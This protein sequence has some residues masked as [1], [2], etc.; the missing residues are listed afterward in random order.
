MDPSPP[1]GPYAIQVWGLTKTF[2]HH[3]VL[4]GVDLQ[5]RKG[6]LLA[7]FGPNGAGKTTLLKV[8][9]TLL[10]PSSGRAILDGLE[11]R[12]E[13][14]VLRR[15]LGVLTHQT[16]LYD[17]LTPYENLQFYGRM[18][19]VPRLPQ[20]IQELLER[21]GLWSRRHDPVRTLS[22]GMQKRVSLARALLHDPPILLL[23]EPEAGL[24]QQASLLLREILA[25]FTRHGR[26]AIM[27][28]HSL[29][30]GLEVADQ[31]AI[32]VGGRLV[33]EEAKSSLDVA[34]FQDIY[35]RHVGGGG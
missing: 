20:R 27:T 24:D 17:D 1:E 4:Q 30:R 10:K 29:E 15:R 9:A 22:H 26:T 7:L 33:Y 35:T 25:E 6:S 31:V 21:V 19:D 11:L 16:L 2:G 5:V 32:L 23:D 34:T 13:G 8:L 3:Q 18:Y 28:T 14:E 12:T